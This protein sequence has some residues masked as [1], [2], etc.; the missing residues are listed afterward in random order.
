MTLLGFGSY[1]HSEVTDQQS[2]KDSMSSAK[3]V[4][5]GMP[6]SRADVLLVTSIEL[7]A[8]K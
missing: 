1:L 6:P 2:T 5:V 4:T 8:M 7:S 3:Q